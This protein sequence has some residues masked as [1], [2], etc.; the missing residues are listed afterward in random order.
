MGGKQVRH[1]SEAV[2]SRCRSVSEILEKIGLNLEVVP[3]RAYGHTDLCFREKGQSGLR[4]IVEG[5][6]AGEAFDCISAVQSVLVEVWNVLVDDR[7]RH[8]KTT[9]KKGK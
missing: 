8:K 2:D 9:T 4:P 5:I 1:T 7:V 3:Y 6:T